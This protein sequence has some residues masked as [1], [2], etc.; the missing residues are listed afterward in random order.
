MKK[1]RIS[2]RLRVDMM[3][4]LKAMAVRENRS[5]NNLVE[6]LIAEHLRKAD[7]ERPE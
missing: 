2:C 6:S 1:I 4:A 7:A 3:D 5:L